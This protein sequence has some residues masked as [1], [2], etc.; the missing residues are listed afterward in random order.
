MA[1]KLK[2]N[3]VSVAFF[4]MELCQ[5]HSEI[6]AT[7]CNS[8]TF[9]YY[10]YFQHKM[11]FKFWEMYDLFFICFISLPLTELPTNEHIGG[12]GRWDLCSSKN[13]LFFPL[14]KFPSDSMTENS[15]V[16][17]HSS[18]PFR[19]FRRFLLIFPSVHL[20][21]SLLLESTFRFREIGV[22]RWRV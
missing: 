21:L 2:L 7:T 13:N 20:E 12:R 11:L 15:Q 16:S 9:L 1:S 22:W 8:L 6:A 14:M 3:V 18:L 19:L 17:S 10:I 5:C 4:L